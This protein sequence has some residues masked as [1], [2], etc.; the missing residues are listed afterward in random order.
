MY[1]VVLNLQHG[2]MLKAEEN[3]DHCRP[4]GECCSKKL[5]LYAIN[6]FVA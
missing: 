3:E 1:T 2:V 5:L 4:M 6:Y